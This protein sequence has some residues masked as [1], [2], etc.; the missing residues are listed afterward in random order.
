MKLLYDVKGY[1][2]AGKPLP[3]NLDKEIEALRPYSLQQLQMELG[4]FA[5][6]S[7]NYLTGDDLSLLNNIMLYVAYER[8]VMGRQGEVSRK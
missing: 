8:G 3:A 5:S 2:V 4:W 1:F 7:L 6:Q